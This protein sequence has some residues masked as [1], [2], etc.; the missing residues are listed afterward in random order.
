[1]CGS[2]MGHLV[3]PPTLADRRE[4]ELGSPSEVRGPELRWRV[5]VHPLRYRHV[6]RHWRPISLDT[7]R[8]LKVL[9]VVNGACKGF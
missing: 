8:F 2:P 6:E 4:E 3:D 1:M 9:V 5:F 7:A